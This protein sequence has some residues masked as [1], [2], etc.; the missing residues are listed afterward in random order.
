[1][2]S[3]IKIDHA[4][5]AHYAFLYSQHEIHGQKVLCEYVHVFNISCSCLESCIAFKNGNVG[6]W[7]TE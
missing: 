1:M 2:I 3:A 7:F 5:M 4:P 6:K